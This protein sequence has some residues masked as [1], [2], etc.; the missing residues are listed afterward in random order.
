[1]DSW[2]WLAFTSPALL[3]TLT[4]TQFIIYNLREDMPHPIAAR[5]TYRI[6]YLA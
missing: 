1:M 6:L 3:S 5:G 2:V 4:Y